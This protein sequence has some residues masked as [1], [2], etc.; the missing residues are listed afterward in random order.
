MKLQ[1]FLGRRNLNRPALEILVDLIRMYCA[2]EVSLAHTTFKTPIVLDQRPDLA[3]DANTFVPADIDSAWDAN[4]PGDNGFAYYR[5]PIGLLNGP[6]GIVVDLTAQTA[7]LGVHDVLELINTAAGVQLTV[8][9]VE[10]TPI[11]DTSAPVVLKAHPSSLVWNNAAVPQFGPVELADLVVR[12]LPGLVYT[13]PSESA[14]TLHDES[15]NPL[16]E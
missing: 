5:L 13:P 3:T 2:Y 12:E 10:N 15:G 4:F 7:P 16:T 9:D 6:T 1:Y 14:L 8:Q 11:T